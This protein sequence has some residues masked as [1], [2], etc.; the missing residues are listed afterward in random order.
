MPEV[1]I[2]CLQFL[3]MF[4]G[5][6]LFFMVMVMVV[7]VVIILGVARVM[8][9]SSGARNPARQPVQSY[10]RRESGNTSW[11][12]DE[13]IELVAVLQSMDDTSRH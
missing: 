6:Q 4:F 11:L 1:L 13:D 5:L 8:S 9:G 7:P 12:T 3:G 10:R 2:D